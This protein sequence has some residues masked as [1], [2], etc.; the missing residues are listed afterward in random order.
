[1]RGRGLRGALATARA[2]A[3]HPSSRLDVQL[4]LGRQLLGLFRGGGVAGGAWWVATHLV[5]RLDALAVPAPPEWPAAAVAGAYAA[6]LFVVG[7]LSRFALHAAMHRVPAL[8]AFH[9][10]HHSAARLSP[11]TFH[12]IHPVESALYALRSALVT[13]LV[14]GLFYW[15]FRA[16]AAPATLAGVPAAGLVLNLAFGNLRHS[17]VWL[18]FPAAVEGWL[19]SP[20]QHQ[21][22]HMAD[23]R[24]AHANLGTWL[25][26]WDRLTGSLVRAP[27][28]PPA[29]F[30][31]PAAARNHGDDL[32]SAWFGPFRALL[33]RGRLGPALGALVLL[34]LPKGADAADAPADSAPAADAPPPAADAPPPADVPGTILITDSR[35]GTRVAGSAQVLDAETLERFEYNDIER[36]LAQVPGVTTRTEDGFGLRPNIGIRGASSDRS[37]KITLMEDGVLMAPAPYAAP[38]AYYFPM[39]SRLVGVEVFKGPAATRFGPHT[40]GGAIN[41]RTRAVPAAPTAGLDLAGGQFWTGKAHGWA[42]AGD[43]TRGLLVEGIHLRTD[44]F[45]ELDTGGPTGFQRSDLLAKG[46]WRPADGHALEA[47]LGFG[48]ERSHET[49][50][51]LTPGDLAATPDRRY[52]A[53]ARDLMAWRRTQASLAWEARPRDGVQVRTTVYHHWL[54]RQWRK[55]NRF[56]AGIDTHDLLIQ[57]PDAG[58]GALYLALLRG[59]EDSQ[60]AAQALQIGTNDRRYQSMGAQA[61]ARWSVDG[62]GIG[63]TLEAGLRLHQ[64]IVDRVH[65]E[66]AHEMRGGRPRPTPGADPVILLDSHATARALAAH[67]HEDLRLGSLHV[68]PGLRVEHIVTAEADVGLPPVGPVTRTI[69]LP[70]LGL[71]WRAGPW[72]DVY[73]GSYRGFSPVSPGQPADV[74]PETAWNHEAGLRWDTGSRHA[75]L[76]AFFNDYANI[77]GAC[78]LSA[79]CTDPTA[80]DAQYNGGRAWIRGIEA[81][82]GDRLPLPGG[83]SLPVDASYALTDGRFL[84]TF[85]SAFPQY[86]EV[87]VGDRLPYVPVHQ[88]AGRLA[89]S[90]PRGELGAAATHRSEMLDAAGLFTEPNPAPVP[91]FLQVDLS[92]RVQLGRRAALY[93]TATNLLDNRATASWRPFGARPAPPRTVLVG[94]KL[95]AAAAPPADGG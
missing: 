74:R 75:E 58:Q 87:V 60:G 91:A 85:S 32:L 51:G 81:L 94:L 69:P 70:A 35:G 59:D 34:V 41:V 38:A 20:A 33:Q 61:V 16:Q 95:G 92:A 90:H 42:G 68:I 46:A 67:L 28:A 55:F 37:A 76:T 77:V 19:L 17:E 2:V 63:H 11:L 72:L 26:L 53:S 40:V 79:G 1:M 83:W 44:G 4:L 73:A 12:R 56:A 48:H 36:V 71:L 9:Q 13:G 57:S 45:K 22:H 3:A 43:A 62:G 47:K 5:R 65:D 7:D 49:Y 89:L 50:L 15:I 78:A 27:A 25:A 93:G 52:A 18:R 39:S 86:G 88:A 84:S 31:L 66:V 80:L 82:V 10:V 24:F 30:G 8:W 23:P 54:S 21:L 6:T 64:D 29:P 14:A